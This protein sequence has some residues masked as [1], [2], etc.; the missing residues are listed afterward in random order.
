MRATRAPDGASAYADARGGALRDAEQDDRD[1]CL[2]PRPR[3]PARP[4]QSADGSA[5]AHAAFSQAT[6]G[7]ARAEAS[8]VLWVRRGGVSTFLATTVLTVTFLINH[9]DLFGLRQVR[10]HGSL[11]AHVR[12]CPARTPLPE[13][14]YPASALLRLSTTPAGGDAL[15]QLPAGSRRR[16]RSERGPRDRHLMSRCRTA[17]CGCVRELARERV[18]RGVQRSES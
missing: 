18:V 12:G 17:A 4:G 1:I 14:A 9:F 8:V 6:G 11:A 3:F 13:P 7:N 10:P 5:A 15:R 2:T 16:A